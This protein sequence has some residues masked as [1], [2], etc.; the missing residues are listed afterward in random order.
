MAPIPSQ[1]MHR[2]SFPPESS[3]G[4]RGRT[5]GS[6]L[7]IR[8]ENRTGLHHW[9]GELR[10]ILVTIH[11]DFIQE[12]ITRM[13]IHNANSIY[14]LPIKPT[15]CYLLYTSTWKKNIT[16]EG[17]N[18]VMPAQFCLWKHFLVLKFPKLSTKNKIAIKVTHSVQQPII[19]P[20]SL[21]SKVKSRKDFISLHFLSISFVPRDGSKTTYIRQVHAKR[22]VHY[23]RS[24]VSSAVFLFSLFVHHH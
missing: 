23:L 9:I 24:Q 3:V 12:T 17:K 7:N 2:I 6:A 10:S 1:P 21:H 20:P 22:K 4:T 13:N 5:Q 14:I 15:T 19:L 11:L 8:L 18:K 16:G